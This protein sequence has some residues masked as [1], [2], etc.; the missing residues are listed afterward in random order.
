MSLL[1]STLFTWRVSNK[2]LDEVVSSFVSSQNNSTVH[3]PTEAS[4]R[5]PLGT[6][7]AFMSSIQTGYEEPGSEQMERLLQEVQTI[8]NNCRKA[9]VRDWWTR[10]RCWILLMI[11]VTSLTRV[12]CV[13]VFAAPP[14]NKQTVKLRLEAAS[15]VNTLCLCRTSVSG[16]A[17]PPASR[18]FCCLRLTSTPPWLRADRLWAGPTGAATQNCESRDARA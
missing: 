12:Q 10:K 18:A 17:Q 13:F 16:R 8:K 2:A 7:P 15:C 9:N 3:D 14:S 5:E 11:T 6:R 4:V 1:Y